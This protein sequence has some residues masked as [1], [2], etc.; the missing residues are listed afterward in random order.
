MAGG[1][2]YLQGQRERSNTEAITTFATGLANYFKGKK[3]F[4]NTQ[5]LSKIVEEGTYDMNTL[6]TFAQE[7]NMPVQDVITSVS[8]IR[9]P[10]IEMEGNQFVKNLFKQFDESGGSLTSEQIKTA[11][12]GLS[13]QGVMKGWQSFSGYAQTVPG[14]KDR[15]GPMKIWTDINGIMSQVEVDRKTG[16]EKIDDGT[17]FLNKPETTPISKKQELQDKL[18]LAGA[19]QASEF[20]WKPGQIQTTTETINGK[21]Y[22][23]GRYVI[24]RNEDN[25]PKLGTK[26]ISKKKIAETETPGQKLERDKALATFKSNLSAPGDRGDALKTVASLT[27]QK[28]KFNNTTKIDLIAQELFPGKNLGDNVTPEEKKIVNK[29]YDEAITYYRE[30]LSKKKVSEKK[31]PDMPDATTNKDRIIKD[32]DTGRRYKSNGTNW[33]EIK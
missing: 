15:I 21:E 20:A 9:E 16:Q 6:N 17:G 30:S 8:K 7:H 14:W 23:V 4:E 18:T 28:A 22:E 26:I 25:T 27:S 1:T 31:E 3:Q 13:P 29:A 24:G 2:A 12:E 11:G 5:E 32:T 33:I 19:K 10:M